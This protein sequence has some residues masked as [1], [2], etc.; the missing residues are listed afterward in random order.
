MVRSSISARLASIGAATL[1]IAGLS[2]Q[3]APALAAS[4]GHPTAVHQAAPDPN[5]QLGRSG[6]ANV[7]KLAFEPKQ[8]LP[9]NPAVVSSTLDKLEAPAV[10]GTHPDVVGP[11]D[12]DPETSSGAA[13]AAT[14]VAA[15]GHT[16]TVTPDPSIAVGPDEVLQADITG[17]EIRDRAGN[18]LAAAVTLPTFF[19]LPELGGFTTFF[20]DPRVMFD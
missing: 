3:A 19:G 14:P 20:S 10:T 16:G 2:A 18:S 15:T 5:I 7:K 17:L 13:A 1:L 9:F 12:P 8:K 4:P 11:P 6:T